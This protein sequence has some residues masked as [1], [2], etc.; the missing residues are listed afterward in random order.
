MISCCTWRKSPASRVRCSATAPGLI[1]FHCVAG[2]V[3]AGVPAWSS[4]RA[5]CSTLPV[6]AVLWEQRLQGSGWSCHS[7]PPCSPRGLVPTAPAWPPSRALPL[8][9]PPRAPPPRGTRRWR[10]PAVGLPPAAPLRAAVQRGWL[11]RRRGVPDGPGGDSDGCGATGGG[12]RR[13]RPRFCMP[14]H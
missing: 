14:A 10:S 6:G 4:H 7:V 9:P 2:W 11:A 3:V 1:Q 13:R 12:P 8:P 5:S